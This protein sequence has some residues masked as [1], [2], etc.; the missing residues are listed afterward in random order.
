MTNWSVYV[1]FHRLVINLLIYKKGSCSV[2][3]EIV[4]FLEEFEGSLSYKDAKNSLI[5]Y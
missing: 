2:Y 5:Y 3:L 4:D 1:L